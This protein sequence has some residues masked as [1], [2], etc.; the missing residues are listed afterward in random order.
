MKAPY[1]FIYS[2][3]TEK[4]NG[5]AARVYGGV[6]TRRREPRVMSYDPHGV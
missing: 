5:G 1:D 4:A 3:F 6:T 2:V